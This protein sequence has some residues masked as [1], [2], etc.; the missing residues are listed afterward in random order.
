MS[1]QIQLFLGYRQT[2]EVKILLSQST[3]WKEAKVSGQTGLIEVLQ[4][5]HDYIGVHLP[6]GLTY[7][8]II[9]KEIEIKSQLQHYCPKLNLKPHQFYLFSQLFVF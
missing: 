6:S 4:E 1:I 7:Q 8:K 9:E 5:G 2:K 3:H